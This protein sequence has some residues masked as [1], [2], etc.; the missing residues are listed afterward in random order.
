[1]KSRSELDGQPRTASFEV[2]S[3]CP[4]ERVDLEVSERIQ[5][6]L[7]IRITVH[8][9]AGKPHYNTGSPVCE[10]AHYRLTD[11]ALRMVSVLRLKT[12]DVVWVCEHMGR[13]VE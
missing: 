12:A 2:T 6:H 9:P 1:M 10:G 13:L 3:P 11:E 8:W 5:K 7:P 4:H